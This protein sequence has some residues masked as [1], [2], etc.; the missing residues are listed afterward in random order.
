[1]LRRPL[2]R[3]STG[4]A[5]LGTSALAL[6]ASGTATADAA[7]RSS[8]VISGSV[9]PTVVQRGE[10]VTVTAAVRS[11]GGICRAGSFEVTGGPFVLR[12]TE[13][14]NGTGSCAITFGAFDGLSGIDVVLST[15][16][17]QRIGTVTVLSPTP[18]PGTT[19]TVVR[20]TATV[21][22]PAPAASSAAAAASSRAAAAAASASRAAATS[23]RTSTVTSTAFPGDSETP[24]TPAAGSGMGTPVAASA[25]ASGFSVNVRTD[26]SG[27]SSVP[28]LPLLIALLVLAGFVTAAGRFVYAHIHEELQ[29]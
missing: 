28:L 27:G 21:T 16:Q 1:M 20:R 24:S 9:S 26:P 10:N 17:R 25:S 19:R 3:V 7:P 2:L 6:L 13:I 8:C 22:P 4:A 29:A 11:S 15:G 18:T 23:V 5:L 14:F 12:T